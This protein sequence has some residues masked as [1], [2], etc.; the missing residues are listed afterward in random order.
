MA[1]EDSQ[2]ERS[3]LRHLLSLKD[4]VAVLKNVHLSTHLEDH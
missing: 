4:S 3:L 1:Y 2:L